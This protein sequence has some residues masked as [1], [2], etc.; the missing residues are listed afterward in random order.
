MKPPKP[1]TAP[2]TLQIT[3]RLLAAAEASMGRRLPPGTLLMAVPPPETVNLPTSAI[4][5]LP[6]PK[7]PAL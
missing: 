5:S 6:K 4:S 3:P 7:K 2:V 1:L